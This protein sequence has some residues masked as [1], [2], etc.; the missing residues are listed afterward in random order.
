M[1]WGE[2]FTAF[3]KN[4]QQ[5]DCWNEDGGTASADP[6]IKIF[7]FI[8]PTEVMA[9]LLIILPMFHLKLPVKSRICRVF[10]KRRRTSLLCNRQ[11]DDMKEIIRNYT[12]MTGKPALLPAWSFGL[13]LSTSFTTDYDEKTATEFIE[14]MEKEIFRWKCFI[15]TVSG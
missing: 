5:I 6:A 14:G 10:G 3:V 9:F 4:G 1:D 15:L 8:S 11:G 12:D 2:R 7:H 13:W